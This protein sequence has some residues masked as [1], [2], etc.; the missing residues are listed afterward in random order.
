MTGWPRSTTAFWRVLRLPVVRNG[1]VATARVHAGVGWQPHRGRIHRVRLV[2]AETR[3]LLV[4]VNYAA[5]QAQCRVHLAMDEVRGRSV[6]LEDQIGDQVFD[7]DGD[8]LATNGLYVDL[9]AWGSHV[10]AFTLPS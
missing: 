6:R 4:V 9:P 5:T 7:R 2:T 3:R 8:D 1:D 10:L